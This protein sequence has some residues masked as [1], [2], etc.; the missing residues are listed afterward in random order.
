MSSHIC[1]VYFAVSHCLMDSSGHVVLG[2]AN[3][4]IDDKKEEIES[5]KILDLFI[6]LL[7]WFLVEYILSIVYVSENSI[8][9]EMAQ[10]VHVWSPR[11]E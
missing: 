1:A 6:V 2:I 11:P 10:N 4:H 9:E 7:S 8:D 3:H 5:E